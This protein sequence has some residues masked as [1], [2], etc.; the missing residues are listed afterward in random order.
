VFQITFATTGSQT[1]TVA[2]SNGTFTGTATF[3][4]G[5]VV[6]VIKKASGR[7]AL[8][9]PLAVENQLNVLPPWSV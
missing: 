8:R 7:R 2:D 4:V 9:P 5:L 3:T 6:V 1:V